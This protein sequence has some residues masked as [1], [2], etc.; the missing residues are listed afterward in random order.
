MKYGQTGD[1]TNKRC[2]LSN[3]MF[4]GL[5]VILAGCGGVHDLT[6]SYDAAIGAECRQQDNPDPFVTIH[7]VQG[8]QEDMY[9]A[10]LTSKGLIGKRFPQKS[11]QARLRSDGSMTFF[12]SLKGQAGLFA[13]KPAVEASL[14]LS[15]RDRDHLLVEQFSI[16][17]FH[18]STG[19]VL[20]SGDLVNDSTLVN[21]FGSTKTNPIRRMAGDKGLCLRRVSS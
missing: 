14:E 9:R 7:R 3:G 21:V 6:G 13:G 15:Q 16:D 20:S 5:V 4:I 8:D 1:G 12:F 17:F 18:P 10:Q 2:W 11:G 19:E